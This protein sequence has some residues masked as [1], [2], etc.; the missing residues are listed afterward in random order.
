MVRCK[1]RVYVFVGPPPLFTFDR[2]VHAFLGRP[3]IAYDAS[4]V[5]DTVVPVHD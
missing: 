1:A 3:G 2:R 4:G 5:L